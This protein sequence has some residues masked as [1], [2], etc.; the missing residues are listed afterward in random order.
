[1]NFFHVIK[2]LVKNV[3]KTPTCVAKQ[4]DGSSFIWKNYHLLHSINTL[5]NWWETQDFNWC[6]LQLHISQYNIL[7]FPA[8]SPCYYVCLFVSARPQG[9]FQLKRFFEISSSYCDHM[10]VT[11]SL[12]HLVSSP[13]FPILYK[14]EYQWPIL[15][16][17]KSLWDWNVLLYHVYTMN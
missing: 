1:M 4:H 17:I 13:T 16:I 6:P 2:N 3:H 10:T 9:L 12:L 7:I 8:L 11:W 5:L 15:K 14:N